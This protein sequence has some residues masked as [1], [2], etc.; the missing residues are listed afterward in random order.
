M[1]NRSDVTVGTAVAEALRAE[2]LDV[3]WNGSNASRIQVTI[4]D[5][6]K[7]LPAD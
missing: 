2:G 1:V 6:R 4:T 3:E 7:P 5:W